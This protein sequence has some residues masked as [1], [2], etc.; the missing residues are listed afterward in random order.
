M[1]YLTTNGAYLGALADVV[2]HP[3][4]KAAPRGLPIREKLNYTFKVLAPTPEPIVTRDPERNAVIA[5][6]TEKEIALMRSGSRRAEDWVNLS[7]FWAKLVNP[8]GMVN[9]SYGYLL[10]HDRSCGHPDFEMEVAGE[11]TPAGLTEDYCEKVQ[12][13]LRTPWEWAKQALIADRDTRQAIIKLHKR[14]HLWVGNKDQVCTLHGMFMLRDS[15]L[16][17][18]MVM[19]SNDLYFGTVYDCP[20]FISLLYQMVDE[21]KPTYPDISVGTYTHFAH[22]LHVYERNL[23]AILKMLG[24]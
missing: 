6:Y 8:D 16:N 4:F 14:Q 2:D 22:S 18:T 15:K 17:L 10:W 5:A 20:F 23:P 13:A 19:R 21:L 12:R 7:K 24:R 11:Y 3:D 1:T 9:S